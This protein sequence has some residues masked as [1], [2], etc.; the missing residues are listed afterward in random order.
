MFGSTTDAEGLTMLVFADKDST[1]QDTPV[2]SAGDECAFGGWSYK[3]TSSTGNVEYVSGPVV[4][5]LM[6]LGTLLPLRFILLVS[7]IVLLKVKKR[8]HRSN[9]LFLM[10][11]R[12]KKGL[13]KKMKSIELLTHSELVVKTKRLSL[14]PIMS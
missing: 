1:N 12:Y 7:L 2:F 6:V 8:K 9:R 11:L 5:S 3:F 14:L 10:P 13:L 4:I